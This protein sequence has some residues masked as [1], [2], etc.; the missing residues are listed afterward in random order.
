MEK[1]KSKLKVSFFGSLTIMFLCI[2][3]LSFSTERFNYPGTEEGAKLLLLEFTKPGAN[4]KALSNKLL[5]EKKDYEAYFDKSVA[6]KAYTN[7]QKL[8]KRWGGLLIKP[9]AGQTSL[10]MWKATV[11]ELKSW[12]GQARQTF[13]GGY[14]RVASKLNPGHIVIRFKFVKPSETLGM[15]FDGLTYVNNRWVIFPKPWRVLR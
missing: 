2:P 6:N 10:L 8:F 4:H 15:A 3:L 13:P 12:T 11:S 9:K 7:Y 14:R 1:N 5:P